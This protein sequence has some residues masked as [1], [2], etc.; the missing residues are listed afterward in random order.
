M[1]NMFAARKHLKI[2]PGIKYRKVFPGPKYE[3]MKHGPG[4]KAITAG[5]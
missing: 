2:T 3:G 1:Y 4:T 5:K